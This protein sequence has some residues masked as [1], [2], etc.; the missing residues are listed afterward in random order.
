MTLSHIL[1]GS[2]VGLRALNIIFLYR[3]LYFLLVMERVE[4]FR[5]RD[6]RII[7]AS[8]R[9]IR[10]RI[11]R[12]IFIA[13]HRVVPDRAV[14]RQMPVAQNSLFFSHFMKQ[15]KGRGKKECVSVVIYFTDALLFFL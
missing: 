14:T 4:N 3:F 7:S 12:I 6:P 10:I 2:N 5:T 8:R 15:K 9:M 11:P 13:L 1:F